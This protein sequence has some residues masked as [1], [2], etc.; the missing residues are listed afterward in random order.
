M[1][2]V[3]LSDENLTCERCGKKDLKNTVV[4]SLEDGG[5]VFYGRD[6]AARAIGRPMKTVEAEARAK[7]FIEK[8][9]PA[10]LSAPMTQ[11]DVA[12]YGTAKAKLAGIVF[13]RFGVHLSE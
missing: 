11:R 1:K 4:L 10:V 6:C 12:W 9:G 3:G 5:I 13:T 8:H 7:T 2:I